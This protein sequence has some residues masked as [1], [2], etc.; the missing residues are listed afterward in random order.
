MLPRLVLPRSS[1]GRFFGG[2]ERTLAAVIFEGIRRPPHGAGQESRRGYV[3]I[4][5]RSPQGAL[6]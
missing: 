3:M 6:G 5:E 1:R 2:T 4:I